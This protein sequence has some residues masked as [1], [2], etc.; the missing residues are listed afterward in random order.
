M[1]QP[2]QTNYR[3]SFTWAQRWIPQLRRFLGSHAFRESTLEEDRKE[4]TDLIV[5]RAPGLR[6]AC[7]VRRPG[8]SER[9]GNQVTVTCRR[10]T[11]APCEW[12]KMVLGG[13]GDWF[14]YAHATDESPT[15]GT[16]RPIYLLDLAVIRPYLIEHHGPEH[17]PNKDAAGRRCW[18]YAFPVSGPGGILAHCGPDAV[19]DARW[20]VA[21]LEATR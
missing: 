4:A 19:I 5:L 17:G 8:Y 15:K 16:L 10:E 21:P 6:A 1:S 9:F 14:C 12:D 3:D 13:W 2:E 18:F 20:T 11:G 7:R